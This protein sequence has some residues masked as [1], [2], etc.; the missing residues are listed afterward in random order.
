[1][2]NDLAVDRYTRDLEMHFYF[3]IHM[4]ISIFKFEPFLFL[5]PPPPDPK[6]DGK[7]KIKRPWPNENNQELHCNALFIT[8]KFWFCHNPS[9]RPITPAIK[10]LPFPPLGWALTMSYDH[11][12]SMIF[13]TFLHLWW[14][15]WSYHKYD[16]SIANIIMSSQIR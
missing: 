8:T 1:M 13:I 11:E 4:S 5:P 3:K 16:N 6:S 10:L 14:Y 15:L 2:G 9:T 12:T 7:L